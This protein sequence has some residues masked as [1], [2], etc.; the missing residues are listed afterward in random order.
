[1]L[2]FSF[3]FFFSIYFSSLAMEKKKKDPKFAA[4]T[5][6]ASQE[7]DTSNEHLV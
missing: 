5:A 1:M 4:T 6:S 3:S 7:L 2:F